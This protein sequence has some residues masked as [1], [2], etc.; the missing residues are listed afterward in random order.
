MKLSYLTI[1][2]SFS[3]VLFIGELQQTNAQLDTMVV[4][5]ED[6]GNPGFPLKNALRNAVLA[7][8]L[9]DGT[10]VQ[11]RVYKL[12]QGG[13]YWNIDRMNNSGYHLRIVGEPGNPNDPTKFPPVLQRV[14]DDPGTFVDDKLIVGTGDLTLKNVYVIH[15]DDQ[16]VQ[17]AYQPIELSGNGSRYTFDNVIFE[18]SNFGT[19]AVTSANNDLFFTNC[20]FRNLIGAPSTQ[21]WEGRGMSL[22]T[23]QDTVVVENCTFFNVEFTPFQLE[24]GAAN[25][26]RFNHNTLVNVGR[27]MA[28][29]GAWWREAYFANSLIINGWWHG[30]GFADQTDPNRDPRAITTGIFGI[31]DLPSTYGPEEGRRILLANIATWR[32]PLFAAYYADSIWAQGY[33]NPI[34]REDYLDVYDQMRAI[35]TVWLANRPNFPTYFSNSFIV[36]SMIQNI[37]DLR[38]G[39][40]PATPYFWSLPQLGGGGVCNVCPTWAGAGGRGVLENFTY[41]DNLVGSDGLPLGDL[42]WFPAQKVIFETNKE[43][44]VAQLEGLAGAEI[45]FPIVS[46]VEMEDGTLGGDASVELWEGFSY[47]SFESGGFFEWSFDLANAGQYDLNVQTHMRGNDIRGQRVIVNGVSLH[48]CFGWGEYIWDAVYDGSEPCQNPNNGM[49][50][51][52]F[53]WTPII[54]AEIMEAGALTLPAGSN[55]IRFEASWGFQNFAQVNVEPAGTGVPAVQL[56]IPD[57]TDYGNVGVLAEGSVYVPSN[58]R[59]VNLGGNGSISWSMNVPVAGDYALVVFYQIPNGEQ[60]LQLSVDGANI[61]VPLEGETDSVGRSVLTGT[62]ALNAG[63]HTFTLSGS[64]ALID[65]AQLVQRLV[66]RVTDHNVLPD[67]FALLQNYPNPFNPATKIDFKIAKASNVRLTIYNMLGQRVTTLLD[68]Y[69]NAGTYTVDFDASRLASGVYFYS[70]E[71]GDFKV[72]KKMMLL[73]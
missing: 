22:W 39:I 33:T 35:D 26:L 27:N 13:V 38:A 41:T 15:C 14:Y 57:A 63:D 17:T 23:D 64:N 3:F 10:H 47:F 54:Q 67:D 51:N 31:D 1:L 73:K 66:L 11:N 37:K 2:L 4:Q 48:E 52:E 20:I 62:V 72:S 55:T 5:W 44:Y 28:I 32:D 46:E 9:P 45:V 56:K 19:V 70:I 21:Q 29:D 50:M 8:T 30:E 24:G 58:F 42:N 7:D 68:T 25:Y 40:T 16:G 6:T 53:T 18:R 12:L 61:S 60:S 69:M 59:T 65:W 49:P 43:Q 34:T 36:D 71:A